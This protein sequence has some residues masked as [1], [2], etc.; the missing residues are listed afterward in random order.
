MS[1]KL[2]QEFFQL[3]DRE[4]QFRPTPTEFDMAYQARVTIDRI[5]FAIKHTEQFG[6]RT[7][8]MR[9]AGLQLLDALNRLQAVDL[10]FQTR[11]RS[12][13]GAKRE[14]RVEDLNT[15]QIGRHGSRNGIVRPEGGQA[16]T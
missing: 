3:L 8:E 2:A 10:R 12:Q 6:P 15:N 1:L 7:G 16:H 9:E 13:H 4:V 11:S 14:N 5:R